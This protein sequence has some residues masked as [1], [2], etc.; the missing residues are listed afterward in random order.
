MAGKLLVAAC[1]VALCAGARI[2]TAVDRA[3]AACIDYTQLL[4]MRI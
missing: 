3:A 4:K 1:L 2:G